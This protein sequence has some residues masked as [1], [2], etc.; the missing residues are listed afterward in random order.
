MS[1]PD[2]VCGGARPHPELIK[3]AIQKPKLDSTLNKFINSDLPPLKLK[4]PMLALSPRIGL[5]I[6]PRLGHRA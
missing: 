5:P 6:S 2:T 1:K 4:L 3:D